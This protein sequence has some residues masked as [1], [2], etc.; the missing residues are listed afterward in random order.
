MCNLDSCLVQLSGFLHKTLSTLDRLLAFVSG[1]TIVSSIGPARLS[2]TLADP[3]LRDQSHVHM[4]KGGDVPA[5]GEPRA[6]GPVLVHDVRLCTG[7]TTASDSL[8]DGCAPMAGQCMHMVL[9]MG[10]G[11]RPLFLAARPSVVHQQTMYCLTLT[12][13][14]CLLLLLSTA[15]R[16]SPVPGTSQPHPPPASL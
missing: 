3:R 7:P 10:P 12:L 9:G 2:D 13:N 4:G 14:Q 15:P 16:P 8:S 6:R 1:K 5:A 11:P